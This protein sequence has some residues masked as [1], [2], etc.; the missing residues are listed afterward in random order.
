MTSEFVHLHNHSDYSLL[1]GAQT[2]QTLVNTVDDLGMDSVA[3]TEH[4][5][6]FSVI[7]Y[8]KS[9]KSAG[10]KPIIGCE[11][12]VAS[13][14]LEDR[15]SSEKTPSHLTVLAQ[16]TLGYSNLLYLVSKANTEG[17]YYK[18]R[19]DK[20]LLS[21]RADGLIVLSGCPSSEI[22]RFLIDGDTSRAEE[23]ARFYK[24]SFSQFY[25]EL[26][27]HENLEFLDRLNS[28]LIHIAEKLDIPLIATNDL[29]YVY[30]EDAD[31]QDVMVCIQTNTTINDQ[32]RMKMS[33]DSYYL[34]SPE[35][36]EYLFSGL[37]IRSHLVTHEP[38]HTC[39][40][41]YHAVSYHL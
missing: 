19:V 39:S 34:K 8:Y 3:L 12:Y 31:M 10:I 38:G 1:D 6:M 22:S 30:K 24:D 20:N 26:Q 41:I 32:S 15:N 11:L 4:G 21:S 5:N 29:H 16:N 33:D 9:A 36:M 23:L 14:S 40:C 28:G 35:E 18:P 37:F 25:L 27:R 17:F 2:V 13:G 7:P